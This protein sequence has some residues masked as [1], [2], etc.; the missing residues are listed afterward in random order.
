MMPLLLA[1]NPCQS[2]TEHDIL[3]RHLHLQLLKP[4]PLHLRP[5]GEI[6]TRPLAATPEGREQV[7]LDSWH[8]FVLL[9]EACCAVFDKELVDV[10]LALGP[11][12]PQTHLMDQ[13]AS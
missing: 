3:Q 6:R 8:T 9:L 7:C 1:H 12:T 5:K 10:N 13:G 4:S 11:T 2:A